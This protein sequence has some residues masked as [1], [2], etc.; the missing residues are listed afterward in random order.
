MTVVA[1][2]NAIEAD[3]TFVISAWIDSFKFSHTA[4]QVP[5]DR[6]Y[7][8]MWPVVECLLNCDGVDTIVAHT[9]DED[10]T[11]NLHGFITAA[12]CN[13]L[14]LV[15][16]VYVKQ[17]YRRWGIARGLFRAVGVDPLKPFVYT[18][19]TATVAKLARKIPLARWEPNRSRAIST[20]TSHDERTR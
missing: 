20:R 19:K 8:T 12:A 16:Y 9:P 7:D 4:G 17:A 14:P 18:F 6:W 13:Q 10:G 1:Y 11:A 5:F 3:R 2:R 15:H